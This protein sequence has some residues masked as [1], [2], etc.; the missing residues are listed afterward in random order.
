M[1][2]GCY[3]WIKSWQNVPSYIVRDI[4]DLYC[5]TLG[6]KT[7]QI[8]R[9]DKPPTDTLCR[10]CKNGQ[11]SVSHILNRCTKLL[12]GP[13][14][15]RHDEVFQCFFNEVLMR[16]DLID[17]CPPWFT[18][19]KVKPYYDNSK[20]SVWWNIPEFTG[21]MIDAD[22]QM[23]RPDGKLLLKAEKTIFLL[24]ITISW[25]DNRD[26]R[27]KEKVGKYTSIRRNIMRDFPDYKVDQITLVMDSLGGYSKNLRENIG[28]IFENSK[29]VDRVVRKMQKCVLSGSVHIS[30]CFKLET[31][32]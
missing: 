3:D 5:Q 8:T 9:S 25:I 20:A 24:E 27:Y 15:K 13:Y 19:N 31:Q 28:K 30:R 29:V 6:T 7:F 16:Y 22:A 21:A 1:D 10:M 32:L 18:Q 14:T 23:L 12:T 4:Y 17:V 26:E 2:A 11:E